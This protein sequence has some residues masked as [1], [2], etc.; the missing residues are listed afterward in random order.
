MP[1]TRRKEETS[2]Q[3][4][5]RERKQKNKVRVGEKVRCKSRKFRN[6]KKHNEAYRKTRS[7]V[8]FETS[9]HQQ[10]KTMVYV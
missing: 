10:R 4:K 3:K 1:H 2:K 6:A 5:D 7:L 8:Q 9:N